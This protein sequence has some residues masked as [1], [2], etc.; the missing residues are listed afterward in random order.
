MEGQ[1]GQS[2]ICLCGWGVWSGWEQYSV[3]WTVVVVIKR[4]IREI[5]DYDIVWLRLCFKKC[6]DS[7][8]GGRLRVLGSVPYRGGYAQQGYGDGAN[9]ADGGVPAASRQ[10]V[11][12]EGACR[13]DECGRSGCEIAWAEEAKTR[14]RGQEGKEEGWDKDKGHKKLDSMVVAALEEDSD[15][16]NQEQDCN[17][18]GGR[19]A[20]SAN[21]K[22][23]RL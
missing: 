7:V 23:W 8:P 21:G 1:I 18:T 22:D 19:E 11:I 13:N 3:E 9:Y 5:A 14:E 12:E 20:L 17:D 15:P 2:L 4:R 16:G 6:S 10:Q